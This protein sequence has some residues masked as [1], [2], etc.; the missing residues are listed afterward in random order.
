MK[1][2]N[3]LRTFMTRF[4]VLVAGLLLT[5]AVAHT[6]AHADSGEHTLNFKDAEIRSLIGTVSEITGKNFIIDPQVQG[7][8]TVVSSEPLEADEVYPVFLSILRVHG[9][10]AVEDGKVVRIVPDSSARQDGSVPVDAMR[11]TGDEPVT[12]ILNLEHVSAS[13]VSQLLRPL[14]PQSA[15]VAAHEASNTVLLSD[16]SSNVERFETIVRRLDQSSDQEVEVIPLE[17][18]N[19][20][21]VVRIINQ[22]HPETGQDGESAIA[23]E[24]TNTVILGGEPN[25]RLRL[26]ALISHLDTPLEDDGQTRVIHLRHAQADSLIPVLESLVEDAEDDNGSPARIRAHGE[27]NSLVITASPA[28]YRNISSVV[29]QLDVRRPQVLVEAI[30]AEVA[31]D[32]A[33]ELGVQWQFFESGDSGF[34]GGTNFES[35]GRNILNLSAGLAGDNDGDVLPGRGMNLG[36]VSGRSSLLGVEVVEIGALLRALSTDA[37]SNVLSTPSI[38]TLDNHEAEIN[39]GQEVPFLTGQFSTQGVATGEGQVNPFQT[40]NREEIGV[41]LLVTPHIN[42]GDTVVMDIFQEVSN[43]ASSS[44]A[45]DLITN[46]RTINT[47]VMVEDG[48]ILVLGG[49]I[50]EELEEGIERVPG[51]SRIPLLGE[52]FQYRSTSNVK[53]N[54]MVFIRPRILHDGDM[55]RGITERRYSDVRDEQLQQREQPRGMTPA[56]EMPLLP[57]LYDFLQTAPDGD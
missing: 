21:E 24:R 1:L 11:A 18:A 14:L 50:S 43:L 53:R 52:L 28:V 12:R 2:G 23:D 40:I 55:V 16:R 45:V 51:L 25:R 8:V 26:R 46:K 19:V 38:V 56:E 15:F 54:L 29:E 30:I 4:Q 3:Q 37:N 36:Y 44:G 32:T 42:E 31:V 41:K 9:Y 48:D 7:R 34:F 35:G 39:V 5:A 13:E 20:S 17:H 10:S 33:Q 27:T 47:R 57:E 22:V 49:L 6:D